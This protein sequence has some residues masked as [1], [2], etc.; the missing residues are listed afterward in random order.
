MEFLSFNQMFFHGK[1]IPSR[2]I[3][4]FLRFEH[5]IIENF[6][7]IVIIIIKIMRMQVLEK[8]VKFLSKMVKSN[9]NFNFYLNCFIAIKSKFCFLIIRLKNLIL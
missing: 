1:R 4:T 5:F 3:S 9:F 7:I 6:V 8:C 2:F